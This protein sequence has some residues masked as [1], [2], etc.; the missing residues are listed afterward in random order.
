M[1]P[2]FLT[3]FTCIL[4][5]RMDFAQKQRGDPMEVKF[6]IF[7][8]QKQMLPTFRARKADEKNGVVCLVCSFCL[9][10]MVL[11]MS[12]LVHF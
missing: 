9:R 11:K 4:Q 7:Q 2:I 10:V 3:I 8:N 1:S 6:D 5:T 12:K